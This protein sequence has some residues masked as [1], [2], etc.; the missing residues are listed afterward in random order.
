MGWTTRP[1]WATVRNMDSEASGARVSEL[2]KERGWTQ[3][4]LAHA[5]G[6]TQKT[7]SRIENGHNQPRPETI[8]AL[9]RALDV[10][11]GEIAWLPA[12]PP[13]RVTLEDVMA[14][15]LELSEQVGALRD[16]LSTL[17]IRFL[18]GASDPEVPPSQRQ[19]DAPRRRREERRRAS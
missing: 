16:H 9:A 7:I 5:S 10:E 12:Q 13:G 3:D 14:A 6:V 4:Q 17:E 15:I 1:G 11:P 19:P 8:A 2:R 18:A